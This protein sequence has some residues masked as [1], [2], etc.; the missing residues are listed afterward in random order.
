MGPATRGSQKGTRLAV[1]GQGQ[2]QSPDTAYP[3]RATPICTATVSAPS[4]PAPT[5][6]CTCPSRPWSA[7][8]TRTPAPRPRLLAP[9]VR[10]WPWGAGHL[11]VPGWFPVY[12]SLL[13][14]QDILNPLVFVRDPGAR[15]GE[16][17]EGC[18]LLISVC[19]CLSV[20]VSLVLFCPT[21]VAT[22]AASTVVSQGCCSGQT[23]HGAAVHG[24]PQGSLSL[25]TC[26]NQGRLPGGGRTRF[27]SGVRGL[28][29]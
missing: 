19:L 24:P 13:W 3:R 26:V 14:T 28:G 25:C 23:Q 10:P 2:R 21:A 8:P 11:S 12:L 4:G 1:E 18:H 20:A 7:S 22:A 9:Q 29:G 15:V 17:L 16:G 5:A 27:P 6:A